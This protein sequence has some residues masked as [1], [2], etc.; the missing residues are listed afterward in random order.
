MSTLTSVLIGSQPAVPTTSIT[1]VAGASSEVLVFPSGDYYLDH[2]T[3]ALSLL[4]RFVATLNLHTMLLGSAA[5]ITRSGK[6]LLTNATAFAID[7]WGADTTLRDLLGFKA[8]LLS[9]TAHVSPE[10][11]SLY[12]SPGKPEST[13]GLQGS[14]GLLVTDTRAS[15]SAPGR[16]VATRNNT[17]DQNTLS[18]RFVKVDRVQTVPATNGTWRVF[19]EDTASLFRRFYVARNVQEDPAD[20]V[21]A[22][23]VSTRIPASVPYILFDDGPLIQQHRREFGKLELFN[24]IEIPVQ[25]ALE[26][27]A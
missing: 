19:W 11:S 1:V 18:W 24:R 22:I 17:W 8:A 20:D 25:T 12:W 10:A 2:T 21:T 26:Y 14:D 13:T 5:V 7:S 9:S 15:R 27:G 6:Q 23:S 3:G 4:A 16:V